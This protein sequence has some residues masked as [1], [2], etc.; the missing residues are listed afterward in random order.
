MLAGN[1]YGMACRS[2]CSDSCRADAACCSRA[3]RRDF[4]RNRCVVIGT[5]GEVLTNDH[6]LEG[7]RQITGKAPLGNPERAVL[8]G[9][10]ERN[11]L[12]V[13]RLARPVNSVAAF[14]EGTPVRAGDPVVLWGF[15]FPAF[16]PRMPIFPLATGV[17]WLD[18]KMT[19]DTSKSARPCSPVTAA[20][21][22]STPA[23]I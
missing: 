12:A 17:P 6:V 3:G 7:C 13:I 22:C 16:S 8:I 9:R 10:D 18:F 1:R 4:Q 2:R 23:V 21:R 14:R 15:L 5:K 11:D 20:A 19:P